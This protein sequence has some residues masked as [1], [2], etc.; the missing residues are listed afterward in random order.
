MTEPGTQW[1]DSLTVELVV[2]SSKSLLLVLCQK[3][4]LSDKINRERRPKPTKQ[5]KKAR[6]QELARESLQGP[7]THMRGRPPL[8]RHRK[9]T[10]NCEGRRKRSQTS[11][12][13]EGRPNQESQE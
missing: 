7:K 2:G 8:Q 9:P 12:P 3:S 6:N 1:F 11:P 10:N 5:A 13:F 4:P